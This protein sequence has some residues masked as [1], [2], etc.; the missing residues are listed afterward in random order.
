[1][2][3]I[4]VPLVNF[5]S[6]FTQLF[7]S[8]MC[9]WVVAVAQEHSD[10]KFSRPQKSRFATHKSATQYLYRWTMFT[11]WFHV[12]ITVMWWEEDQEIHS[13]WI[14]PWTFADS[15]TCA[16]QEK[17]SEVN[18]IPAKHPFSFSWFLPYSML[19]EYECDSLHWQYSCLIILVTW[20]SSLSSNNVRE[21]CLQGCWSPFW[22]YS[23]YS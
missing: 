18:D 22:E 21:M 3:T 16:F 12:H 8:S 17:R 20:E 4:L 6:Y 13:C 19:V 14:Y 15:A 23:F 7:M 10:Y 5:Y 9:S 1:M 11:I 2:P